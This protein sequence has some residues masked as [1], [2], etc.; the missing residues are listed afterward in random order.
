[1]G[2]LAGEDCYDCTLRVELLAV[3]DSEGFGDG[4]IGEG[5]GE[6]W[7]GRTVV[8]STILQAYILAYKA[9]FAF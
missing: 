5:V 6:G 1:M 9:L 3:K 8:Y 2:W 7:G 4:E